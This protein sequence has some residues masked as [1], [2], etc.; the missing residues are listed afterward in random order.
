MILKISLIGC[1]IK[2]LGKLEL[3][4]NRLETLMFED[5]D[6][7]A[8]AMATDNPFQLLKYLQMENFER[9]TESET[10]YVLPHPSQFSQLVIQDQYYFYIRKRS[11]QLVRLNTSPRYVKSSH[12]ETHYEP[13]AR[14]HYFSPTV[15]PDP[16]YKDSQV[17]AEIYL[18]HIGLIYV[19]AF[20]GNLFILNLSHDLQVNHA[21]NLTMVECSKYFVAQN[22]VYGITQSASS[23]AITLA[24]DWA[25]STQL[26]VSV[27]IFIFHHSCLHVHLFRS[28]FANPEWFRRPCTTNRI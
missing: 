19:Y 21:W 26:E 22:I 13:T 18:D 4:H 3:H 5:E 14:D 24:Y 1:V 17:Y 25:R 8:W 2:S 28:C 7:F 10:E 12:S 20:G 9:N 16:L 6:G 27:I 11:P 23:F 15:S